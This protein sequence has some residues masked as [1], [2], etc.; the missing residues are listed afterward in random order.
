MTFIKLSILYYNS[1]ESLVCLYIVVMVRLCE[2]TTSTNKCESYH[3]LGRK[4]EACFCSTDLCN[5]GNEMRSTYNTI[6]VAMG[7]LL[8]RLVL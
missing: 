1:I 2:S 4:G 3:Y 8:L 7:V 6:L 5:H